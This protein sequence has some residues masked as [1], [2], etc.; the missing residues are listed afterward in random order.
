M[1]VS[2][3]KLV[4]W[5]G[6]A[7]HFLKLIEPEVI[8]RRQKEIEKKGMHLLGSFKWYEADIIIWCSLQGGLCTISCSYE[9]KPQ[10]TTA[11]IRGHSHGFP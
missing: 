11:V 5:G 8:L 10:I 2:K 4:K 6:G 7:P 3:R 9:E 1:H